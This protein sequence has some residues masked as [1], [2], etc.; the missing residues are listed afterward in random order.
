VV[1]L[2]VVEGLTVRADIIDAMVVMSVMPGFDDEDKYLGIL[3]Q[4][5]GD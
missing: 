1:Q 2:G 5:A 4:T 3:R